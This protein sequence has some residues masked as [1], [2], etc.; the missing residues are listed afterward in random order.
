MKKL[1]R[2][3]REGLKFGLVALTVASL[4]LSGAQS[5]KRLFTGYGSHETVEKQI[6]E[7][8]Q[9]IPGPPTPDKAP[10]KM[11]RDSQPNCEQPAYAAAP[12]V[13][14]TDN[15]ESRINPDTHQP[16]RDV[17]ASTKTIRN[18]SIKT[19]SSNISSRLALQFTLVGAKPSGTS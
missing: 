15:S 10:G 18:R 9:L 16:G 8:A 19:S 2:H 4:T 7:L 1:L 17:F 13:V 11:A 6:A 3:V 14:K 5:A 12:L